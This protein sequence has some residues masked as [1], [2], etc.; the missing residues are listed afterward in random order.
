M[1]PTGSLA[2][3]APARRGR[4][5][6]IAGLARVLA[7]PSRAAMLDVLLDG[8]A[9][10]IGELARRAG[11]SAATASSH[12]RQLDG[13]RLIAIQPVGRERRVRLAGADIAELLERIAVLATS[14]AP[15]APQLDRLRFART[16]YDHLAGLLGV[17]VAEALIDRGWLHPTSDN[18]EPS[19]ALFAWLADHGH[20]IS[21]DHRRPLSRACVDWTERVP[22]V[23]GRTGAALAAMFLDEGWVAR[24]RGTR[25][26]RLTDRGRTALSRELGISLSFGRALTA[27]R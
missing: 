14:P 10:T 2:A 20:P 19:S 25:A 26:L 16:C 8:E 23:A 7:D 13:A 5:A 18:L 6:G 9:H 4:G 22:H 17:A 11:I 12:A 3:L 15:G 27:A 21:E 24:V 1:P